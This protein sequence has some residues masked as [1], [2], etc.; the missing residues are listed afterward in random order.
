MNGLRPGSACR[1]EA[2]S[3]RRGSPQ[4]PGDSQ[5]WIVA[6]ER[7]SG[8]QKVSR[9]PCSFSRRNVSPLESA[10]VNDRLYVGGTSRDSRNA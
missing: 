9:D 4:P 3:T 8:T 10:N 5:R 6:P 2:S 7:S 1:R